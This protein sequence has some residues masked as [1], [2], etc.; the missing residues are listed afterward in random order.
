VHV[1]RL[2]DVGRIR[3]LHDDPRPSHAER[4]ER[5][6]SLLFR[7]VLLGEL[8]RE[9]VAAGVV[10]V[11]AAAADAS[12]QHRDCEATC[13]PH[14]KHGHRPWSDATPRSVFASRPPVGLQTVVS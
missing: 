9:L 14:P 4:R 2:G 11:V 1:R 8:E 13:H 3:Q 5:R 6:C 7:A 10:A 12:E